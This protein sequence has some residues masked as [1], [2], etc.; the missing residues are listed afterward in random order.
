MLWHHYG[1]A[2]NKWLGQH[3]WSSDGYTWSDATPAYNNSFE[4]DDGRVLEPMAN[5]GAQRPSL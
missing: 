5:G 4:L 2:G 1:G 3:A